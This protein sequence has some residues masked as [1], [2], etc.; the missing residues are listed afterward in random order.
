MSHSSG[1]RRTKA[2]G[3]R[4]IEEF[5]KSGLKS[6]GFCTEKDIPYCVFKYWL[7]VFKKTQAKPQMA[8]FLP[9]KIIASQTQSLLRNP[10]KIYFKPGVFIE[11][12]VGF[13]QETFKQVLGVFQTCG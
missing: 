6:V 11:I 12:P 1:K 7:T 10:L 5:Y 3:F 8:N 9:V 4:L 2:Q 13:D